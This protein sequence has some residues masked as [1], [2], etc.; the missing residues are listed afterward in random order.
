M[1]PEWK[2]APKWANVLLDGGAE[3]PSKY[4]WAVEHE[5][6]AKRQ[7][8]RGGRIVARVELTAAYTLVER[9]PDNG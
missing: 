8:C 9:R 6:G 7:Y 5:V 2:D 4:S 1:K 3:D